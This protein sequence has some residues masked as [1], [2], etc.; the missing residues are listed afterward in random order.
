MS[1]PGPIR[2]RDL[3]GRGTQ[4]WKRF[5]RQPQGTPP[6]KR[7]KRPLAEI[8]IIDSETR[9]KLAELYLQPDTTE[10]SRLQFTTMC[11]NYPDLDVFYLYNP[12][13][14]KQKRRK[15]TVGEPY[16]AT[17]RNGQRVNVTIEA[18]QKLMHADG[19]DQSW[20]QER[21]EQLVAVHVQYPRA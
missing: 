11:N 16:L 3:V 12:K 9:N 18:M 14:R 17:T 15:F 20:Q 4:P 19:G 10:R 13:P 5:K 6:V 8:T 1:E 7:K 21:A 2:N